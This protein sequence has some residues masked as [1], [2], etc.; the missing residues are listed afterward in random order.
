M[1][2]DSKKPKSGPAPIKLTPPPPRKEG[3]P[4][5]SVKPREDGDGAKPAPPPGKED[6]ESLFTPPPGKEEGGV[7][8]ENPHPP[9]PETE[10]VHGDHAGL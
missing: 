10:Y 5:L 3:S 7:L 2:D 1:S 4:L 6:G 9:F 8:R